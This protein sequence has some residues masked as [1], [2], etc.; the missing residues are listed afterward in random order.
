MLILSKSRRSNTFPGAPHTPK[1][2][3]T[4]IFVCLSI[5]WRADN[6]SSYRD[7]CR[8]WQILRLCQSRAFFSLSRG[9]T[10]QANFQ[11]R[12]MGIY[13]VFRKSA[14]V[15]TKSCHRRQRNASIDTASAKSRRLDLREFPGKG[16]HSL[17]SLWL[18]F[19]GLYVYT[20]K[21]DLNSVPS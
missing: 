3:E 16:I 15:S 12:S 7:V 13:G 17:P 5:A 6:A 9:F 18:G 8:A 10:T 2:I 14:S 4:Q 19:F 21:V 11:M 20:S 1:N